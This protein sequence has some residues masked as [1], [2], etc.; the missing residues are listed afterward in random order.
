MEHITRELIGRLSTVENLASEVLDANFDDSRVVVTTATHVIIANWGGPE[1]NSIEL[2]V[3]EQ[4][5]PNPSPP[6]GTPQSV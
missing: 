3:V 4:N 5:G 2:K 6:Q 1:K